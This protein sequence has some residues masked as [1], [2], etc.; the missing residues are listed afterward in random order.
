MIRIGD[1]SKLSRVTVKTLRYYD[2]VGLLK[3]ARMDHFTGYRYYT[4][5]QLPRLNRILALKDLGFSLEEIGQLL[6]NDLTPEQMRGMLKLRQVEIRQRVQAETERLARVDARLRQ[7][8]QEHSMSV[9]D[10][11]I[12]K[13]EPVKVAA[14]RDIVP[15]PPDQGRLWHELGDYLDRQQ[16]QPAGP[17]LSLYFDDEYK[18]Y[19]WDIE[20]CQ[21]I[22]S[23][24]PATERIRVRELPGAESMA[25]VVHHGP[26]VTI[27]EA[28]DALMKWI[29]ENGYQ[30]V[31]PGR[32]V[33]LHEANQA[34]QNDPDTVTEVQ[35]PVV[36]G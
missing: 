19:D 16:V 4:Y 33:Y 3:P 35:F 36:K 27:G 13:V 15:R 23:D 34:D 28:Y 14:L 24:L 11:V 9:Y 8:E 21:P 29:G 10:I 31:G 32:E 1:F 6:T 20:V 5:E 26:F 2:Q 30:I 18:E 7:I 25:C 12:K 17:C 22:E